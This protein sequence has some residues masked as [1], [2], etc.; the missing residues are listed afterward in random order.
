[1]RALLG[2]LTLRPGDTDVEYFDAYTP[3]QM[4][5]AESYECEAMQMYTDDEQPTAFVNLD[6]WS[7]E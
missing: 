4:E 5:F 7:D 3:E 1:M 2:F 6:D